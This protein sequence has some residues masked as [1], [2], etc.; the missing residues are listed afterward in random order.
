MATFT[1]QQLI[2]FV[3]AEARM[4]DEQRFEDWLQ[5]FTDDGFYWM[6]LEPGQTD[7]RLHTSLL[8]ED[9]LLLRVRVERLSG[10]RTFSQQPKSRCHHLLQQPGIESADP[11]GGRWVLRTPFHYVETRRDVQTLFVGW[12]RHELVAVGDSLRIQ[13]KRVDLVNSDAAFANINLFM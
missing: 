1:D 3:Y 5:L 9:K 4:L 11:A 13:L 10:A 2:D 8:Y 6:P 12:F 7:A